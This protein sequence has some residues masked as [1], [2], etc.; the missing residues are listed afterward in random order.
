MLHEH[1]SES[2]FHKALRQNIRCRPVRR[3]IHI[4]AGDRAV[5][6]IDCKICCVI[7]NSVNNIVVI[8]F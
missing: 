1:H 8:L 2:L 3:E 7:I 4:V 5:L 6:H